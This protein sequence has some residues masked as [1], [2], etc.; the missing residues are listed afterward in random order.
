MTVSRQMRVIVAVTT[1]ALVAAMGL[2]AFSRERAG[3]GTR[4]EAPNIVLVQTDDQALSQM[5]PQ[6]M[7]NVSKLDR[8][9][10]HPVRPRLSDDPLCCPSRAGLETGRIRADNGVLRNVY[11]LLRDKN[12]V[13]PVG[14]T[15]PGMTAHIGKFM[16]LYRRHKPDPLKPAPGW[17]Q[18]V[19]AV[20]EAG[21]R[22]LQ[23][24][25]VEERQ[26]G[27]YGQKP[28]TTRPASSTASPSD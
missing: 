20:L 27:D 8:R 5:S 21:E 23:L 26:A 18:L 25:H 16:N 28:R 11:E 7:P 19:H 1:G 6:Y 2:R 12:N 9:P 13:L 4:A 14:S 24:R 15:G 3:Q 10:G 22:L 17:D